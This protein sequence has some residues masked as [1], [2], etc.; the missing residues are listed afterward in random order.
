MWLRTQDCS[1]PQQHLLLR[2][3]ARRGPWFRVGALRYDEVPDATATASALCAAGLLTSVGAPLTVPNPHTNPHHN[4]HAVCATGPPVKVGGEDN[5][6][7]ESSPVQ[8]GACV[9]V[10]H[11]SNDARV[12]LAEV[13][14][15]LTV[16]ELAQLAAVLGCDATGGRDALLD[17]VRGAI[18]HRHTPA[19]VLFDECY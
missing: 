1:L 13:V 2:L 8:G 15:V 10:A 19:Q 11:A 16:P 9:S 6:K 5:E 7:S 4:P 12:Q 14:Q 3:W 18:R 17:N